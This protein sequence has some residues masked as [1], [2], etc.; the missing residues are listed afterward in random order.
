[1]PFGF[2]SSNKNQIITVICL[3]KHLLN[4]GVGKQ[5][6]FI[7]FLFNTNTDL[8]KK[9]TLFNTKTILKSHLANT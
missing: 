3:K 1:M 2:L 5:E 6:L 4:Y 7:P 8:A 9:N